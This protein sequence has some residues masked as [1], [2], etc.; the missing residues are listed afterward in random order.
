MESLEQVVCVST[1]LGMAAYITIY[2]TGLVFIIR[3]Y[4]HTLSLLTE[5]LLL[6]PLLD[7]IF[8][9]ILYTIILIED[10]DTCVLVKSFILDDTVFTLREA[11]FL[12]VN[13]FMLKNLSVY[14][15]FRAVGEQQQ[16]QAQQQVRTF[17]LVY[18]GVLC[19]FEIASLYYSL[20]VFC[21]GCQVH[22]DY[23]SRTLYIT[24]NVIK[25]GLNSVLV[26]MSFMHGNDLNKVLK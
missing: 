12:V 24:I 1:L 22:P 13:I 18:F 23:R 20:Y 21:R 9:F 25:F 5:I 16:R 8:S 15:K 11:S 4:Y 6:V 3:R 19:V 2:G 10:D 14:V 17:S 26:V 7:Y